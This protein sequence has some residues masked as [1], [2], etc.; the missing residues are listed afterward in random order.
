MDVLGNARLVDMLREF[1]VDVAVTDARVVRLELF[2]KNVDAVDVAEVIL[3]IVEVVNDGVTVV[4]K[5][6]VGGD[7]EVIM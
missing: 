5:V 1:E 7:D 4:N 2:I 6:V 3:T